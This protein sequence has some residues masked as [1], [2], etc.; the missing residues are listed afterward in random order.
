MIY[1]SVVAVTALLAGCTQDVDPAWQLDHDRLIAVRATPNRIVSG[2]IARIDALVGRS[3][4]API[5]VEPESAEVISPTRLAAALR[6]SG[7]QWTVAAPE[8]AELAAA[9]DELGLAADAPVPLRLRVRVA[10]LGLIGLKVVWLGEQADNPIIGPVRIAGVD[11]SAATSLTVA[12]DVD[13]R[14]AVDF[15]ATFNINW[16]TSCGAMH[17]FDLAS[18]YLRVEPGD[19]TSGTLGVVVRDAAG[20]VAWQLWPITAQ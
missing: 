6:Q 13:I 5:E 16:L 19:P 17:D 14:L 12:R 3:G 2:E 20:G 4:A 18:A 9:R 15:D 10:P 8:E 1:R 7:S 11:R